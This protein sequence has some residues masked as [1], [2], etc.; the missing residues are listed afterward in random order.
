MTR[1]LVI[2]LLALGASAQCPDCAESPTECIACS[3][4]EPG[5]G[6][7]D[8]MLA[9]I[10]KESPTCR[11]NLK[12][13]DCITQS[14]AVSVQSPCPK[15]CTPIKLP[16]P[17]A[18]PETCDFLDVRFYTYTE[19]TGLAAPPGCSRCGDTEFFYVD[20]R[21]ISPTCATRPQ[22]CCLTSVGT[23][24][25]PDVELCPPLFLTP[26]QPPKPP[27]PRP[28]RPPPPRPPPPRPPPARSPPP[29]KSP[30]PRPPPPRPPPPTKR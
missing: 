24:L 8:Y 28:P 18:C 20:R 17:N 25:V 4:F 22:K 3:P 27:P 13:C 15:G 6:G 9:Y 23:V 1:L 11:P 26:P 10:P 14:A 30:P 21:A 5:G 2:L 7:E 12:C 19:L 16:V 29:S